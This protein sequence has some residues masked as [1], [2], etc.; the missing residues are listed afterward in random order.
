[1]TS[2]APWAN[3][4]EELAKSE[5]SMVRRTIIHDGIEREYFVHLPKRGGENLPVVV[6]IH[7]Y[8]STA[9]GFAAA[10]GLNRHSDENGYIAVYPQG[11][12]FKVDDQQGRSYRVTSWNDLAANL[13]SRHS[14]PHCAADSV[15]YPCPPEC[16]E[17]NRCAW[18]SCYDDVGFIEKILDAV[19][20][21][22]Q[23]NSSRYYLL[24]VSNGAMMAL[25][26]TC[27]LS[28]RFAA[29]APIIGQLAPG[30][31]CG[32]ETDLP[33][34]HIFGGKDD[35]VRFDG[36]P[37]GDGFIYASAAETAKAW[38]ATMSCNSGPTGW[39][40]E[41]SENAGL[42]CTAYSDCRQDGH[43]VVSC[44]DPDGEHAWPEQFVAGVPPTCITPEQYDSLPDQA[45]C[46]TPSGDSVNLGM[47]LVWDFMSRYRKNR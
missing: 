32:P 24:G 3:D 23:T 47:D 11:S 21:E 44:M 29:V 28:D 10:H 35:T 26:L 15:Q 25:R 30:Y 17:C 33:M 43:E 4:V 6:G 16:G 40:N 46:E 22:F 13:G 12:H 39:Q 42:I 19:Q 1:V 36:Q 2:E 45:R 41:I 27:N 34:L 9:T 31:E 18:T 7:G 38:A 14:G 37:G 8:T 20:S 5:Q